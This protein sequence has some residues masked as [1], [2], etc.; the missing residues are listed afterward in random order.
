MI[1]H[2]KNHVSSLLESCNYIA[3]WKDKSVLKFYINFLSLWWRGLCVCVYPMFAVSGVCVG[4]GWFMS[5]YG[6]FAVCGTCNVYVVAVC[7]DTC[8]CA[9]K[10]VYV[11]VCV[12]APFDQHIL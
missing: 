11:C 5:V 3:T 6:V 4:R 8:M 2:T 10:Y 9:Y 1:M 12:C 7:V